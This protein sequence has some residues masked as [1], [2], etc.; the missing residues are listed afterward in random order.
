MSHP[1]VDTNPPGSDTGLTAL[2]EFVIRNPRLFVLTGAGCSVP[3]GI[4]DYRDRDGRWKGAAPIQHARFMR[5]T[6]ARQHYWARSLVG[7]PKVE[8]AEPNAAHRALTGLEVAGRVHQLVTQNVDGLHQKSGSRRVIDLHGRLDLVDCQSCGWREARSGFQQRLLTANPEFDFVAGPDRPD[9]DVRLRS[10]STRRFR[11]PDC[12][13]CGGI[14]K[15]HV[16][17]FGGNVPRARV[18]RAMARL[19]SAD[20]LLAVG[21]SLAVYSGYRFVRRAVECGLPVAA[22]NLGKTRADR[23]LRVKLTARC[24]LALPKLLARLEPGLDPAR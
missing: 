15:P 9:G 20:G 8:A 10:G 5:E 12:P 17:F 14:V 11:V 6:R 13:S 21:T 23:D 18:E 16:V 7:W 2:A 22:V 24:D 3:S 1:F 4:P 19:A